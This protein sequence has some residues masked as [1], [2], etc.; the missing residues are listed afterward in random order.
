MTKDEQFLKDEFDS[1]ESDTEKR[2]KYREELEKRTEGLR[3]K[4]LMDELM[5]EG[6][7]SKKGK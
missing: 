2:E 4:K 5:E 7:E 6:A 1:S 3:G